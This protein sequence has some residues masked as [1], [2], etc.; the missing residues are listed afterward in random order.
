MHTCQRFRHT[1]AAPC[2]G[3]HIKSDLYDGLYD[4]EFPENW[5]IL[6]AAVCVK[7]KQIAFILFFTQ[8]K[9]DGMNVWM[10]EMNKQMQKTYCVK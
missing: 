5:H 8:K 10:K 4:S 9:G 1:V 7:E 3:N 2:L 6:S